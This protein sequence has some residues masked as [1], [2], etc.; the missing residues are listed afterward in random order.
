MTL[1]G[2]AFAFVAW[3]E[4]CSELS[5][6]EEETLPTSISATAAVAG[7]THKCPLTLRGHRLGNVAEPF[8]LDQP[9]D[10]P[11]GMARPRLAATGA[12]GAR[13]ARAHLPRLRRIETVQCL[14]ADQGDE[15]RLPRALSSLPQRRAR[16]LYHSNENRA[17]LRDRT[18]NGTRDDGTK[19]PNELRP[20]RDGGVAETFR[21]RLELHILWYVQKH[22]L[23]FKIGQKL[24]GST[25]QSS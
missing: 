24:G 2:F 22:R 1:A 11:A 18:A 15:D 10:P 17:P 19:P 6:H 8:P 4:R 7:V 23:K 3:I 5:S 12:R 20:D 25:L 13:C 9:A 16:A 14:Y 21:A